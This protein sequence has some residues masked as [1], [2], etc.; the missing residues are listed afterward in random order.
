MNTP[1][2][3]PMRNIRRQDRLLSA[4]RARELIESAQYG[5]LSMVNAD[6]GGYG[7]PMSYAVDSEGNLYFHCAPEG[8]KLENLTLDP[9]VTFTI[10]GNTE[11]LPNKFTTLYESVMLFGT[12]KLDLT[13]DERFIAL[14]LLMDKY[15]SAF[16]EVGMKYV[17]ASFHRTYILK[18]E[19][20]GHSAKRK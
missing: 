6:G 7:I 11:I 19:V 14:D 10:V 12:M 8:H 17:K 4:E 13:E 2:K 18:M 20:H 3:Q 15:S 16:K 9:R 1:T 5:V